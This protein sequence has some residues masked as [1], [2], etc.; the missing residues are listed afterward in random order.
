MGGARARGVGG[1]HR[2]ANRST[3]GEYSALDQWER[4]PQQSR[5]SGNPWSQRC[6][7]GYWDRSK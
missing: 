2:E 5:V 6:R 4:S 7:S 3:T 1:A